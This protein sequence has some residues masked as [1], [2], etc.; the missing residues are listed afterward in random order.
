M[1]ARGLI[2]VPIGV[3]DLRLLRRRS[4]GQGALRQLA[5]RARRDDRQDEVVPAAGASRHLGLRRRR[6][7]P[8]CSTSNTTAGRSRRSRMM[9]KMSLVFIFNRVTGEPIFGME[10]RPVPQS[11]VPGE[12]SWP[13]QPFPLKPAPLARND[14]RSGQGLRHADAGDAA[15]CHDLWTKN[16]MYTH[17][18]YTPPG[19]DGHDGDV[20]RDDRR[21]Q[22]ERLLVRSRRSAYVFTNVMNSARSPKMVQGTDRGGTSRHGCARS[23]W[24]GRSGRFWNPGRQDSVLGAAVRRARRGQRQYRRDRLEGAARRHSRVLKST[25]FP[26]TGTPNLGGSITTAAGLIFVGATNDCPL[27]RVRVEDRQAAVGY[28]AGGVR[29]RAADHLSRQGRAAICR[30]RRWRRQLSELAG[31]EQASWRSRL[32]AAGAAQ[33]AR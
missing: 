25:G 31:R 27:P 12:H 6:R 18:I 3:A 24:G 20:S 32:P 10:E 16:N 13:T 1:T 28:R 8:R 14:V 33:A 22:L 15:Y 4:S 23:P 30:R 2:F 5:R 9:T 19:V 21:R 26:N 17:G 29:A 11:S 7:R